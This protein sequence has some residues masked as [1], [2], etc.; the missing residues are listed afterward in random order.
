MFSSAD[1]HFCRKCKYL[2]GVHSHDQQCNYELSV[3]TGQ[4]DFTN[5]FYL[6]FG[7]MRRGK[8]TYQHDVVYKFILDEFEDVRITQNNREGETDT[9][10]AL[11]PD[12][13]TA[14]LKVHVPEGKNGKTF[15]LRTGDANFKTGVM[16]YLIVESNDNKQQTSDFS[17]Y[18][19]QNSKANQL[20]DGTPMTVNFLNENDIQK[21]F[22]MVLPKGE[23]TLTIQV[24][25]IIT[26]NKQSESFK[27]VLYYSFIQDG[28]SLA[29]RNMI[30]YPPS[31]S[32]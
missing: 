22:Y 4:I 24:Q 28:E 6:E 2:I 27:P 11:Q 31:G 17:L 1:R 7:E 23:Q 14:F 26:A 8:V 16:F 30:D 9:Y 13:T 19:D 32:S 29:K 12:K 21:N 15:T 20:I 5:D 3:H 25:P 10:L 18:L